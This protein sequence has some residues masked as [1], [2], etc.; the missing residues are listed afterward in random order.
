MLVRLLGQEQN[1]AAQLNAHPFDDVP[2][3]ASAAVGY[4]Y[5]NKLTN[6]T[7]ATTFESDAVCT[8]QMYATF[9]L[10][11]LGYSDA[12]GD[13]AYADALKFGA[14]KLLVNDTLATGE[15]TRDKMV[16]VSYTQNS[17]QA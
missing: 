8:A 6:G 1:A 4:L 9:A 15:F 12:D 10:R 14:E 11:A 16:A 2:E 17:L 7:S 13:F 5:A 3:W